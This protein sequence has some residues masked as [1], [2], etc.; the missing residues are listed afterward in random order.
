MINK[1]YGKNGYY[2]NESTFIM[3]NVI[4]SNYRNRISPIYT[5]VMKMK[6]D[7]FISYLKNNMYY[8]RTDMKR[9]HFQELNI[10]V[11]KNEIRNHRHGK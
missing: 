7:R 10:T 8:G 4:A 2:R 3:S 6:K 9:I 5:K 11:L 1:P